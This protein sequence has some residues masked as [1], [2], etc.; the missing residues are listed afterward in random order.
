MI[1]VTLSDPR[2]PRMVAL[3]GSLIPRERA[4]EG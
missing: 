1:Y 4:A 3:I 2:Y